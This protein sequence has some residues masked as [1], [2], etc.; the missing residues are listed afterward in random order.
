MKKKYKIVIAFLTVVFLGLIGVVV[1]LLTNYTKLPTEVVCSKDIE[2][3]TTDVK[4]T[5]YQ[6]LI[7]DSD[8]SVKKNTTKTESVYSTKTLYDEVKKWY[9]ENQKEILDYSDK[10][11]KIILTNYDDEIKDEDGKKIEIWYKSYVNSLKEQGYTCK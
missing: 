1:Y 11:R 8:L 7:L 3:E 5:E 9:Q 4:T 10:D 6:H 2:E